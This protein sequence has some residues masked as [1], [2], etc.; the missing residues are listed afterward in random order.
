[1]VRYTSKHTLSP[2][3]V[4]AG[5]GSIWVNLHTQTLQ[6]ICTA[7]VN[8]V[9]STVVITIFIVVAVVLSLL[10]GLDREWG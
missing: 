5:Q 4:L 6:S 2:L 1:M 3:L 8:V 7:T 10:N 9:V